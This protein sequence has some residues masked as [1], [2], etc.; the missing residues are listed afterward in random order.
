MNCPGGKCPFSE[1]YVCH[2]CTLLS[3]SSVPDASRLVAMGTYKWSPLS[4]FV[5]QVSPLLVAK[6]MSSPHY[7]LLSIEYGLPMFL[8]TLL[9]L[10]TFTSFYFSFL[11]LYFKIGSQEKGRGVFIDISFNGQSSNEILPCHKVCTA[12][13]L[14]IKISNGFMN[15]MYEQISR[16]IDRVR[17]FQWCGEPLNCYANS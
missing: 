13:E 11:F 5:F 6:V 14:T 1:V 8:F 15:L 7:N 9:W 12:K 10:L 4:S 17:P 3:W 2:Y 16:W